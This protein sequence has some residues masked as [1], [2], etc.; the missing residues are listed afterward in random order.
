MLLVLH[1]LQTIYT[2]CTSVYTKLENR[3][4]KYYTE[5]DWRTI[6]AYYIYI[7]YIR[8]FQQYICSLSFQ[9]LY[10]Y[11][12]CHLHGYTLLL[13]C[14]NMAI[15]RIPYK[16]MIH[17]LYRKLHCCIERIVGFHLH[18]CFPLLER[19]RRHRWSNN[20]SLYCIAG[21]FGEH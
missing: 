13:S 10:T 7:I 2:Q 9:T 8:I 18:G 19:E 5:C 6:P 11:F 20:L 1:E 3:A 21:N 17:N 4:Y 16:W 14:K 15:S 12:N